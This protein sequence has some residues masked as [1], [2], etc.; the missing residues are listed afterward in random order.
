MGQRCATDDKEPG[1]IPGTWLLCPES[2]SFH[3]PIR[4]G[5]MFPQ[6]PRSEMKIGS[7]HCPASSPRSF[8]VVSSLV[9]LLT[10]IDASDESIPAG[11]GQWHLQIRGQCDR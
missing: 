4:D 9:N 2:N 5:A 11:S 6:S 1:T 3:E 10:F 7:F 8:C